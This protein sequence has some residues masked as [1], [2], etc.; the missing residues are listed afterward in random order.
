[1]DEKTKKTLDL[2]AL[3]LYWLQTY[4]PAAWDFIT[5]LFGMSEENIDAVLK[6]R[7]ANPMKT[8]DELLA[9]VRRG[10]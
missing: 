3:V 10:V 4:G 5:K 8:A 7:E 6:N 1:M 9:D 2:L